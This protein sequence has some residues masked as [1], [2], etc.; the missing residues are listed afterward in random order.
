MKTATK[1]SMGSTTNRDTVLNVRDLKV[2][3]PV[4]RGLLRKTQGYVRAVDGVSLS[5][6][7]GQ[8]LGLVGESGCGKTTTGRAIVGL[9]RPTAGT[10]H[11]Q[12]TEISSLGEHQMRPLRKGIQ[13][14]FQDP[15]SSLDPRMS[16]GNIIAEPLRLYRKGE[17]IEQLVYQYMEM[18]GL[19][20]EFARRYPHE[21]SGGQRQRIGIARAIAPGPDLVI[22][23]EPVSALDVSIQAQI[24]NLMKRLQREMQ[25]AY[26]FIAHDLAVVQHIS[27]HVAVMYLGVIVEHARAED[28]YQRAKHPYTKA[29]LRSIPIPDPDKAGNKEPI[30]GELPSPMDE[31][32]GCPFAGRCPYVKDVCRQVRPALETVSD[33]HTVA[34]HRWKEI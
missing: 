16:I 9:E 26:L 3:F 14:I 21:F 7:A 18:T 17:N 27:D 19:P 12:D 30:K 1:P 33:G 10:V 31:L 15:F 20:T 24:L 29:L 5:V 22:A 11:Y 32:P 8:T 13:M 2:H 28:L 34:C 6:K 4:R 25:V 23:D